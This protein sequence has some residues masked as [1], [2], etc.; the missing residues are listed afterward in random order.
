MA[1]KLDTVHRWCEFCPATAACPGRL[2][3]MVSAAVRWCQLP[4]ST[5]PRLPGRRATLRLHAAPCLPD[6][7]L[8]RAC[9]VCDG[10]AAVPRTGGSVRPAGLPA[11]AKREEE[12]RAGQGERRVLAAGARVGLRDCH[13]PPSVRARR[14]RPT[15]TATG[16]TAPCSSRTRQAAARVRLLLHAKGVGWRASVQPPA[17]WAGCRLGLRSRV[18]H[19][20]TTSSRC[21]RSPRTPAAP[22]A[23]RAGRPA[24][25][26][27]QGV[28]RTR[29]G[30]A[31]AGAER[32]VSRQGTPAAQHAC[33]CAACATTQP[34]MIHP[35]RASRLALRPAAPPPDAPAAVG[36]RTPLLSAA[37]PRLCRPCPR[38]PLTTDA[39]GRSS[40][41]GGTGWH[42]GG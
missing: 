28:C 15:A 29:A 20:P 42:R 26:L 27:L 23:P 38:C 8:P 36:H 11:G 35:P 9:Q 16:G 22:A 17:V 7:A 2:P 6:R 1:L 31:A 40:R 10:H 14:R 13:L 3:P 30:P 25:A 41:S 18:P 39:G 19:T 4:N 37:A 12:R 32:D 34:P 5:R 21:P 24:V 33:E